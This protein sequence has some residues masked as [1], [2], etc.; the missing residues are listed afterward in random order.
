MNKAADLT[1]RVL[2][3]LPAG[4][5]LGLLSPAELKEFLDFALVRRL[6][7]GE[8]VVR[9]N[10]PGDNMMIIMA[11]MLKGCVRSSTGR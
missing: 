10:N 6:K 9:A 11:G 1:E 4:S 3:T 2:E 7:R 8:P 5:V